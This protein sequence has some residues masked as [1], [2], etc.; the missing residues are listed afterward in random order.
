MGYLTTFDDWI[1]VM[2]TAL[3]AFVVLHQVVIVLNRKTSR[4]P[5]RNC[6]IRSVEFM[7]RIFVGPLSFLY[8]MLTFMN[9]SPVMIAL[10]SLL[11]VAFIVFVGTREWG[12]LKKSFVEAAHHIQ[13]KIDEAEK[14]TRTEMFMMNFVSYRKFSMS[15]K[16]YN[17]RLSRKKRSEYAAQRDIEMRKKRDSDSR[18]DSDDED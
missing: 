4:V 3:A 2:Y 14:I 11:M 18:A 13:N 12:G 15:A 16:H 7:G 9:T 5:L 1:F 10:F 8:Y 17:A 6:V